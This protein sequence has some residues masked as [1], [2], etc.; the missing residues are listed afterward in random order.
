MPF[1]SQGTDDPTEEQI[2]QILRKESKYVSTT[3]ASIPRRAEAIAGSRLD[4]GTNNVD[5]SKLVELRTAHETSQARNSVRSSTKAAKSAEEA[6]EAS[7][8]DEPSN[9]VLARK[10]IIQKFHQ[11]LRDADV[12]EERVGTGL[13]RNHVWIGESGNAANAAN[14]AESR[15]NKVR[16]LFHQFRQGAC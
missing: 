10:E 3:L 13:H 1:I 5:L 8:V 2:T 15:M 11:L 16:D 6:E 9:F 12:E 14:A 7:I 4:T